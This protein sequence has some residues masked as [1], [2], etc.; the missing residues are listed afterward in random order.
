MQ[1]NRAVY[2]KAVGDLCPGDSSV[3]GFGVGSLTKINGSNYPFR[4]LNGILDHADILVANLEGL[5]SSRCHD[6]KL[7]FVG[8]PEIADSIRVAGIDIVTLANNHAF[9]YGADLLIETINCCKKAGLEICGLR[10]KGP[11]YCDPVI[12]EKKGISIGFLAYNWVGLWDQDEIDNYLATISDGVVNYT[13]ER[14]RE[15]DKH[16]RQRIKEKNKFVLHDVKRLKKNVDAVILLPHWGYEWTIYPPY[17]VVQEARTFIDAGADLIIGSHS[18][19]AQGIEVY[20]KKVIAYSLGNFL[21]DPQPEKLFQGMVFEA[22][23]EKDRVH[24]YDYFAIS[25]DVRCQPER[26]S[27]AGQEKFRRIIE[28]STQAILSDSA[29]EL[30]DDELIYKQYEKG[31]NRRKAKKVKYL[32]LA[33]LKDPSMIKPVLKKVGSLLELIFMRLKGQRVRW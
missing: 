31:Y 18:H 12:V 17:G 30:L 16:A 19:I 27:A 21:F 10:G 11:Y 6:Q 22:A 23:I 32:F 4:K 2:I 24:K 20:K 14:N 26:A 25:C 28:K 1:D 15:Q 29:E 7:R 8:M 3:D 5:V 9:E 13:W 33:M